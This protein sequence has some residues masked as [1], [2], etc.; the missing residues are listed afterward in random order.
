MFE[1]NVEI[2]FYQASIGNVAATNISF[3]SENEMQSHWSHTAYSEPRYN[4]ISKIRSLLRYIE[5]LLHRTLMF[6]MQKHS[7]KS[8]FLVRW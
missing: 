1:D 5:I 4:E 7:R 2:C 8:G 3:F 6:N